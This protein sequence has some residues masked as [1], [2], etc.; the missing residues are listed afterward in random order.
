MFAPILKRCKLVCIRLHILLGVCVDMRV[1]QIWMLSK[2]GEIRREESCIDYAG[3]SVMVYQ[4]HGLLGNQ[5]WV[6][7]LV[8]ETDPGL[9][10]ALLCC[11]WNLAQVD[12][13]ILF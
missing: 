13:D 1:E 3:Q 7:G 11:V 9:D 5:D 4:C 2:T 6:Y 10:F 8:S 12:G